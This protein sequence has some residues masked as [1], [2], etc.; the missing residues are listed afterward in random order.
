M[1]GETEVEFMEEVCGQINQATYR[2]ALKEYEVAS[3]KFWQKKN[4][5]SGLLNLVDHMS[6]MV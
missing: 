2:A 3:E 1:P 6:I 5:L 4:L